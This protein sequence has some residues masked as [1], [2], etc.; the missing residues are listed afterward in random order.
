MRHGQLEDRLEVKLARRGLDGVLVDPS[1]LVGHVSDVGC[2]EGN[3][4]DVFPRYTCCKIIII[5]ITNT[6]TITV[7]STTYH[8][9]YWTLYLFYLLN[10]DSDTG[11]DPLYISNRS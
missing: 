10:P 11:R 6:I 2:G 9:I 4:A 1:M 8:S 3:R 7:T 5:T